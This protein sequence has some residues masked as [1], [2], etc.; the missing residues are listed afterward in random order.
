MQ[1][2]DPR[3]AVQWKSDLTATRR[4]TGRDFRGDN[5]QGG[6]AFSFWAASDMGDAAQKVV[7][8]A[9]KVPAAA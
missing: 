9:R 4:V 3:P 2:F 1:L 8:A 6:T 7:A 5:P